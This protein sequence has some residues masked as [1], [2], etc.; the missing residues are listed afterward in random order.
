LAFFVGCASPKGGFE[1]KKDPGYKGKLERALVVYYHEEESIP[2]LGRR[3]ADDFLKRLSELLS[4]K[5]VVTEIVRPRKEELDQNTRIRS[6]AD[7]FHPNQ[8]LEFGLTKSI[9][10]EHWSAAVNLPQMTHESSMTFGFSLFDVSRA[11][12]VWRGEV[13]YYVVPEAKAVADQFMG[14]LVKEDFLSG[15][16]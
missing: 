3:F 2:Q 1:V 11:Q 8:V 16:Q 13:R 14:Q 12:I 15:S 10:R 4:Q 5:G 7:R 6:A 9:S